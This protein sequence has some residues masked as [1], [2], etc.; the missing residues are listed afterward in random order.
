MDSEERSLGTHLRALRRKRGLTQE[1]LAERAE[2][3]PTYI[4][5]LETDERVPSLTTILRLAYALEV[6]VTELMA[7][8]DGTEELEN[9]H[10]ERIL[11]EIVGSLEKMDRHYLRIARDLINVLELYQID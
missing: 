3:H 7:V 8:F 4:T 6:D 2:V 1:E 9:C 5:R 10:R 11:Q